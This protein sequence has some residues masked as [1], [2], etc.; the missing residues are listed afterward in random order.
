[1]TIGEAIQQLQVYMACMK[2][3]GADITPYD[4]AI[5]SLEAWDKVK[6][7]LFNGYGEVLDTFY[8]YVT[9]SLRD[10]KDVID[11]HLQEVEE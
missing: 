1:M 2:V 7:E 4:M 3:D 6:E 5:R 8:D 9:I 10:V 11:K